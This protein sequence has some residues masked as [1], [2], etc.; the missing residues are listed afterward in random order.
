[1]EG[2]VYFVWL[3]ADGKRGIPYIPIDIRKLIYSHTYPRIH[4]RCGICDNAVLLDSIERSYFQIRTYTI[5]K[6]ECVCM[7]CN[8]KETWERE[9]RDESALKRRFDADSSY[10]FRELLVLVY[11]IGSLLSFEWR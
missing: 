4:K 6:N 1:M 2:E 3:C 8:H 7:I 9:F 11:Y 10:L 5:I